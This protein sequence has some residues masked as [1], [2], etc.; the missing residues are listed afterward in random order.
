MRRRKQMLSRLLAVVMAGTMLVGCGQTDTNVGA[1]SESSQT[2]AAESAVSSEKIQGDEVVTLTIAGCDNSQGADWNNTLAFAEYEKRLGIKFDGTSYT[3][4]QWPSKLTLMMASD[5]MPDIL[6]TSNYK[7]SRAD[8]EKYAADGYLFDFSPYLD[9]MPNLKKVMDENE[10]FANIITMEDGSIYGFP[11]V[12]NRPPSARYGFYFMSQKWLDNVGMERPESLD[13]LYK[14]LKAFKEQDANGNGDPNDEIPMG[15]AGKNNN[16]VEYPILWAFGINGMR[17][18]YNLQA[19]EDGTVMM[20]DISDQYKE[21]LKY[22]NKLYKEEL[23]N[24]DCYVITTD[25]LEALAKEDKIGYNSTW[26]NRGADYTAETN[27]WYIVV[28]FTSEF[29]PEQRVVLGVNVNNTYNLVANAETE[30]PEAI[31]KFVDYLF[32]DEG[33][34]SC[35]NGYEG[36]SFDMIDVAGVSVI[37]HK[38]YWEDK[39]DNQEVYRQTIAT[40]N[41]AHNTLLTRTGTVYDLLAQVD[42]ETLA[43][44]EVWDATT[45][46]VLREQAM[47]TDELV[48]SNIFPT[49]FYTEEESQERATLSTDIINYLDTA[50]AQFITGEMDIDASWDEHLKKLDEMGLPRLMEIEQNAYDRLTGK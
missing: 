7:L 32:T 19:D 36:I 28:G 48:F 39:Y 49:L 18:S 47:R 29:S 37:S 2:S 20:M 24:Q 35:G 16:G 38:G 15:F 25:E 40:N 50:K 13:D 11:T 34:I 6:A 31:V 1:E 21:F 42:D 10:A 45:T 27:E 3:S 41:S 22:M 33:A 17:N 23:I 5:E 8:L 43:S 26:T 44:Q 12:N 14:V 46:N 4:E 30:H 9:D